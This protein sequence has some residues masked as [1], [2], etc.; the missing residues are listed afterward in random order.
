M[1]LSFKRV[2]VRV[3]LLLSILGPGLITA[4]VDNDSGGIAT[5]SLA[6]T[7]I[8]ITILLI[9]T[10]E[11]TAR[12]GATTGQGLAD[13]FREQFGVKI[14]FWVL[15]LVL[16]ANAGTV[17]SEFSGIASSIEIFGNTLGYGAGFLRLKYIL[18]PLIA[19]GLWKI[20]TEY[21]YKKIEKF[22]LISIV[23]YIAYPISAYL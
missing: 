6:W 2:W 13:L 23:F 5:Y 9:L 16:I 19:W 21:E 1:K 20:V 12:L 7:L 22:F 14:T 11:M 4:I 10:M 8:P 3:L 18:V 17:L 15:T